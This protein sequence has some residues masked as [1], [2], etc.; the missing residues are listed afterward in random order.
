MGQQ[1][2]RADP[3]SA[4]LRSASAQHHDQQIQDLHDPA[5]S[6][7]PVRP[8]QQCQIRAAHSDP[9]SVRPWYHQAAWV[10]NPSRTGQR[11]FA[12][13]RAAAAGHVQKVIRSTI[14]RRYKHDT[15][16]RAGQHLLT[17]RD[18]SRATSSPSRIFQ[19][20][21]IRAG[22]A[23]NRNPLSLPRT[24]DTWKQAAIAVTN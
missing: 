14:S 4:A 3:A 15:W 10:P 23:S 12:I 19:P 8:R 11:S 16:N 18:P 17:N 1:P 21:T 13:D 6:E 22:Q 24:N 20:A 9:P 5:S 7:H 2:H